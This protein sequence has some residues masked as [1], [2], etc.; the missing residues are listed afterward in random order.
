MEQETGEEREKRKKK[1]PSIWIA[2]FFFF[3]L[4][5]RDFDQVDGDYRC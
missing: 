2:G 1:S 4:S 3:F 5:F